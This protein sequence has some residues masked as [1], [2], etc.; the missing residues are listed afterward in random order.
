M[1]PS[2][3]LSVLNLFTD[4]SA[5]TIVIE[6]EKSDACPKVE[7]A[8]IEKLKNKEVKYFEKPESLKCGKLKKV[9]GNM[10]TEP[11]TALENVEPADIY[12]KT[13][14]ADKSKCEIATS[15]KILG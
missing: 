4:K 12:F 10:D 13:T 9:T 5:K 6:W 2:S 15:P 14:L 8:E 11:C 3:K 1:I 7:I